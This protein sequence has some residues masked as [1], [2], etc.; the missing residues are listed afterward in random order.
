MLPGQMG[1]ESPTYIGYPP[2]KENHVMKKKAVKGFTLIELMIVVA[3]IGIL[4]AVA[5]PAFLEYMRSGKGSESDL[6][7]NRAVKS[8]KT[9]RVRVGGFPNQTDDG[10]TP[11]ASSCLQSNKKFAAGSFTAATGG[12]FEAIEFTVEDEFRFQYSSEGVSDNAVNFQG[13]ADLD[14]DSAGSST[15]RAELSIDAAGNPTARFTK[16]GSD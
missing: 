6:A 2:P 8:A 13:E 4:A 1:R 7:L 5:I 16:T 15:A 12:I 10:L 3:I 14:C 11:A 9:Y